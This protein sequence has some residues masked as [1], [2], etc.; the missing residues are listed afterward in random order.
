MNFDF[1]LDFG[2][3]Y[4]CIYGCFNKSF[5]LESIYLFFNIVSSI[6]FNNDFFVGVIVIIF[7]IVVLRL[8]DYKM[9]LIMLC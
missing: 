5:I 7:T 1:K 8:I 6:K 9:K 2:A 4:I 3:I